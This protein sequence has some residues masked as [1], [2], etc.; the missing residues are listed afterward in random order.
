MPLNGQDIGDLRTIGELDQF[1]ANSTRSLLLVFIQPKKL[2][3]GFFGYNTHYD[4]YLLL[5]ESRLG[6]HLFT[7]FFRKSS[8]GEERRSRR[9]AFTCEGARRRLRSRPLPQR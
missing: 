8:K 9:L 2:D 4:H 5:G 7:I 3:F 6:S 1:S